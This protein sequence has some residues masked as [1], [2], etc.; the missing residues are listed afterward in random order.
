MK[1]ME[2]ILLI[3]KMLENMVITFGR[4]FIELISITAN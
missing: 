2:V 3:N 1:N 4:E